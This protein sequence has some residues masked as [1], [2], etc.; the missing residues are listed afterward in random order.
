MSLADLHQ[1]M[2]D[3]LGLI[4]DTWNFFISVHMAI[5]G[6][7][8]ITAGSNVN[9]ITRAL[10]LPAYGGFMFV[11]LRAQMDQYAYL[12][13]VVRQIQEIGGSEVPVDMFQ[14]TWISNWLIPIY[15]VAGGI[16]VLFILFSGVKLV[17]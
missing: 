10:C 9:F 11:N 6:V 17:R 12:E 15:G 2:V 13:G 4:T 8:F 5:V 3:T 16:S 1:L 14:A 7:L